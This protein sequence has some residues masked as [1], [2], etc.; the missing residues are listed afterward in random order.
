MKSLA[1]LETNWLMEVIAVLLCQ[2]EN[3]TLG[4][5]HNDNYLDEVQNMTPDRDSA[6]IDL[7]LS[8]AFI[9]ALHTLRNQ[10]HVL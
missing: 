5:D 6:A 9:E 4:Y 7:T 3:L 8:S 10:L 2:F 1:E